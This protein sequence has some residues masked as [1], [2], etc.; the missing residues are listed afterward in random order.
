MSAERFGCRNKHRLQILQES[1]VAGTPNAIDYVEVRDSDE[2]AHPELRQRTLYVRTIRTAPAAG[3]A[4]EIKPANVVIQGGDRIPR[5]AVTWV[6]RADGAAPAGVSTADWNALVAGLDEP[7]HVLV[8]R[9]EDRGDFSTYTLALVA[10]GS[11]DPAT[12]FDPELNSVALRFKVECPTDLDC[13]TDDSCPTEPGPEGPRIDYLA[14]DF[15]GFRRILLERLS[16]LSPSWSERS[17]AD[18]GIALVEVLAYAADELSWRQDAIATEA[19]LGTARSRVSLRRHAR[20]VDYSVHE[21]CSARTFLRVTTSGAAVTLPQGTVVLTRLADVAD[22]LAEN[23]EELALALLEKP[24]VFATTA[25][26]QLHADCSN[27]AFYGWGDPAACLPRGATAATLVGWP[28]LAVHDVLVLAETADPGSGNAADSNPLHRYAVR[29]TKVTQDQDAAG[30]LFDN[31]PTMTPV[32]ITRIEWHLEDALPEA[33]PLFHEATGTPVAAA[34]G[35][36]VL[37]D[38]GMPVTGETLDVTTGRLAR[39]PLAFVVKPPAETT[40]A[41][42]T[43]AGGDP[44]TALPALRLVGTHL[45]VQTQWDA[46]TDL[47]QSSRIDPSFVVERENDLT[48]RVRF[49]DGRHG[50]QPDP[51]T[52]FVASYR[53]GGGAAGNVGADAIAHL[54]SNVTGADGVSNPL[55]AAGGTD[56][57]SPDEIRRDAPQAFLV[58]ERAVTPDDYAEMSR[59]MGG[60][61]AA[62]ATFRWT[63]SWHTVFVTADR[64]GGQ[65][66]DKPFE[67]ALATWLEKYRMAGYDLEVDVPVYVPLEIALF[68]CVEPHLL[69]TDIAAAAREVL[70]A[71]VRPDGTLGLFHP[72]RHTFGQ[73]VYLS[74]IYEALHAIE[75]VESV[76]VNT[77]QRLGQ[78][79]TSG[80]VDGVLPMQRLEIARLENDPNFPE[81][82]Q[83][84]ITLG[85]GR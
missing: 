44:R 74:S 40:S 51:D 60:V 78:P 82:G 20:L 83:L 11:D 4:D 70:S 43:L 34:W 73:P 28:T 25:A 38:H 42:R 53:L 56:P 8:I 71:S 79:T 35:N 36:I 37:A 13:A 26:A 45:G 5:V 12:G 72:D 1:T 59:R 2:T 3:A 39:Q 84:T 67:G 66:V 14:K 54:V 55:P 65:S 16:Q 77:F 85:G 69:R 18:I 61:Q 32:R 64:L 22:V 15:T 58:Q 49:G 48:A 29:L 41:A 23:S 81:R 47:F 19:Y 50:K 75:G 63:G 31:P 9:T 46:V 68:I 80:L 62:K 21:G 17:S 30:G 52:T 57:E 76:R 7:D 33:L 10:A 27:I 24:E 6:A